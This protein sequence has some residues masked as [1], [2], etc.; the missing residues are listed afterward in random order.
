MGRSIPVR[1]VR[2]GIDHLDLDHRQMPTLMF[3]RVANIS[4]GRERSTE[5]NRDE[6]VYR[7]LRVFGKGVGRSILHF[8]LGRHGHL[9]YKQLITA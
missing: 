6:E 4:H 7:I 9:I 2:K 8:D 1:P 3:M 5:I